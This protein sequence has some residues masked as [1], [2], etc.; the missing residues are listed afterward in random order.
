[1]NLV[2]IS[3]RQ[4]KEIEL[5]YSPSG[6]AYTNFTLA[7]DRKF[8][9][10]KKTDFINFKAFGKT[11]EAIATY[12]DKGK[13]ISITGSIQTGSYE[14]KNGKVYTFDVLAEEVEFIEWADKKPEERFTDLQE[15]EDTEFVPF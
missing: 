13:K 11:A 9:K 15:V 7:V 2:V 8:S 3:G 10:D 1:M 6:V 12:S 4:V 5:K 14:G